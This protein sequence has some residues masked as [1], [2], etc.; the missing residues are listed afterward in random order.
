MTHGK[1]LLKKAIA[2]AESHKDMIKFAEEISADIELLKIAIANRKGELNGRA[3]I[4]IN[5][6]RYCVKLT[7]VELAE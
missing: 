3:Y 2:L 6:A 7:A 4:A 5:D 1:E